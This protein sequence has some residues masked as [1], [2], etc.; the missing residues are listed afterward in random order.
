MSI[1]DADIYGQTPMY[2]IARENRLSLIE[3]ID[4]KNVKVDWNNCDK[5]ASQT[6]LF[7]AAREGNLEM[8]KALI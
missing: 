3:V 6:S 1:N 5:I 4:N 2:Y 7:Y 8:C